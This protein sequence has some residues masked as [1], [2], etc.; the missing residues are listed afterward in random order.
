MSTVNI[1]FDRKFTMDP[2]TRGL[3][4]ALRHLHIEIDVP[5]W[6]QHISFLLVGVMIA[7]SIRGFLN[8]L[9]KFFNEYSSS[10]SSNNIILLLA[11]IMGMYFVSTVLLMRM[12]LPEDYRVIISEVLGDI[13]FNFYHRWFDFLFIPSALVTVIFLVIVNKSSVQNRVSD[14]DK[15]A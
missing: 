10:L 8:Q 5:F 1:V 6:S 9:M 15:W 4:I 7:S 13:E 3:D 11:Q 14:D 2:V 12:S